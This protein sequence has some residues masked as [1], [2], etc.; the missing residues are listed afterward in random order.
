LVKVFIGIIEVAALLICIVFGYKWVKDPSG[1]YEPWTFLA[2]LVF[3]AFEIFRRYKE[4]IFSKDGKI[5][6]DTDIGSR[7]NFC[8]FLADDN[9]T[10]NHFFAAVFFYTAVFGIAIPTV[11]ATSNT[12]LMCHYLTS[13]LRPNIGN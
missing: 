4:A 11:A 3:V 5:S 10:G 12:F 6:A 9:V 1:N 8:A 7:V 13:S 2:G